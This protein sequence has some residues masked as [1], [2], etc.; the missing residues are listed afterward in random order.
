M[1]ACVAFFPAF[2]TLFQG[3]DAILL[4]LLYSLAFASLRKNRDFVAGAWLA[5]GLFRFHLVAPLILIVFLARRWKLVA[6]FALVAILLA[7]L[8]AAVVGWS[9][10]IHYPY[11]VWQLE[12]HTGRSILPPRVTPTLRGLIEDTL[13]GWISRTSILALVALASVGMI[14]FASRMWNR[15]SPAGPDRF[16]L[17]FALSLIVTALVGYHTFLYDL[18]LLLIPELIVLNRLSAQHPPPWRVWMHLSPVVALSFTPIYVV[19]WLRWQR[20]NLLGLILI[21]WLGIL[22]RETCQPSAFGRKQGQAT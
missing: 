20:A 15:A 3:Q 21:F 14:V 7:G 9:N 2:F 17:A 16:D 4:L 6:G 1:L 12:Q 18:S 22:W 5:L 11:H 10:M 13:T 8:S 19:I